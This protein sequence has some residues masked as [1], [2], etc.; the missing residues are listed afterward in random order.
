MAAPERAAA[1]L[2]V[3][4]A[5]SVAAALVWLAF[6][7]RPEQGAPARPEQG[8]PAGPEQGGATTPAPVIRPTATPPVRAPATTAPPRPELA[9]GPDRRAAFLTSAEDKWD[10]LVADLDLPPERATRG[11]EVIQLYRD[12][13]YPQFAAT[14]ARHQGDAASAEPDLAREVAYLEELYSGPVVEAA[15]R[16]ALDE[17]RTL[18]PDA[19]SLVLVRKVEPSLFPDED[20]AALAGSRPGGVD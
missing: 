5:A 19:S 12:A 3:V 10:R 6:A 16:R 8:G 11:W 13:V 2:M 17:L 18:V 20:I 15:R 1:G 7:S 14:A 9:T 4:G